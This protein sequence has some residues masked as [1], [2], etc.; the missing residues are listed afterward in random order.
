ML[1]RFAVAAT[2]FLGW[3]VAYAEV[4]SGPEVGQPLATLK[5]RVVQENA[6]EEPHDVIADHK[7]HPTVYL[8]LSAEKFDRP[9]AKYL[10]GIDEQV[11][12]LQ[13]RDPLAGLVVVWLTDDAEA[14]ITRVSRIQGSLR[15]L[16]AQWAVFEGM[17]GPEGWGINKDA[18]LTTVIS[19]GQDVAA[20]MGYD[21]VDDRDLPEFEARLNKVLDGK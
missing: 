18:T 21:V 11:Q 19:R 8:F 7:D 16:A 6:A 4:A 12:K 2:M 9:A 1:P 20:R 14:G 10:R 13:R 3:T 15:L 5:V 17:N